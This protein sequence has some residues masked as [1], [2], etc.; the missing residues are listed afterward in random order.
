MICQLLLWA[1]GK[2]C[3]TNCCF[4]CWNAWWKSWN[5]CVFLRWLKN[6]RNTLFWQFL[7]EPPCCSHVKISRRCRNSFPVA[8]AGDAPLRSA[9][10]WN[11]VLFSVSTADGP[12]FTAHQI[13]MDTHEP[14]DKIQSSWT[15][16][17]NCLTCTY[18]YCNVYYIYICTSTNI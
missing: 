14:L 8:R 13:S 16:Y 7:T 15:T 9:S 11:Y 12:C 6:W 3:I 2:T 10:G 1:T 5:I 18:V 17:I 4:Q